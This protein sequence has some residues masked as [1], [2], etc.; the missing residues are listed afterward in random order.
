MKIPTHHASSFP[1]STD[2]S[3]A[4]LC[5]EPDGAYSAGD[6]SL[7]AELIPLTSDMVFK[8]VF[9]SPGSEDVLASLLSAVR[10]DYGFPE[11]SELEI[12]NPFNLQ[13]FRSD[14]LSVVDA[15]ARDRSNTLFNIEVQSYRQTALRPGI[16]YYWARSYSAGV[17]EGEP[18]AVLRPVIGVAFVDF[19]IFWGKLPPHSCF[20][21]RERTSPE[22][23]YN[24]HLALHLLE[25]PGFGPGV[26]GS[27]TATSADKPQFPSTPLERWV[28]FIRSAGVEDEVIKKIKEQEPMIARADE[29]YRNFLSDEDSFFASLEHERWVRDRAKMILDGEERGRAEGIEQGLEHAATEMLAKGMDEQLIVEITGLSSAALAELRTKL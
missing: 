24:D 29:K 10:Q 21:L 18:Y 2:H 12:T 7:E 27:R 20:E 16:L 4:L 19:P 28:Y 23:V 14:K 3:S 26:R 11:V 15:R 13:T 17:S 9:G 8:A 22:F 25:L 6:T 1:L 5:H